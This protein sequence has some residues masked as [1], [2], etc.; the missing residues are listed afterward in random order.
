MGERDHV[1]EHGENLFPG[2][3]CK[4]CVKEFRGGGATRLKEHLAGKSVKVTRCTKCPPDIRNYFLHE[5]QRVRDQKKAINDERLHRVQN[6]IPEPDDEDEELHEVLE[7]S[8]REVE[9]QRRVGEHYEHGGGSGGGG[10][11][12]GVKGLFR[13]GTS[14]RERPRDFDVARAKAPVQTR[15]DTGP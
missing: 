6:T 9:F 14:Q 3:K 1:W 13:R 4:Y 12:G 7:V 10:G 5:L 15:I 11:G 2:F 8:R